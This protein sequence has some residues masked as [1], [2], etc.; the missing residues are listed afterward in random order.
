MDQQGTWTGLSDCNERPV[1]FLR[2]G[3]DDSFEIGTRSG[4]WTLTSFIVFSGAGR[5][6]H[7]RR[8]I[9]GNP[10]GP[11]GRKVRDRSCASEHGGPCRSPSQLA[12][13]GLGLGSAKQ[14]Q[15]EFH[16]I[17][18]LSPAYDYHDR[19]RIHGSAGSVR[20]LRQGL[21]RRCSEMH[22]P[23]SRPICAGLCGRFSHGMARATAAGDGAGAD[24]A[25]T[26]PSG[27]TAA[28]AAASRAASVGS[29][30]GILG[31]RKHGGSA[32]CDSGAA[33][34]MRPPSVARRLRPRRSRRPR[35]LRAGRLQ[36][37]RQALAPRRSL[38]RRLM[39]R[40]GLRY[41]L[42]AQPRKREWTRR[43][44][45][46]LLV[47]RRQRL[48]ALHGQ[49]RRTRL[50]DARK[51]GIAGRRAA[52]TQDEVVCRRRRTC[53][54]DT[55]L[56]PVHRHDPLA[57]RF[58]RLSADESQCPLI[59]DDADVLFAL[60]LEARPEAGLAL[61]PIAGTECN[62]RRGETI[63]ERAGMIERLVRPDARATAVAAA[64]LSILAILTIATLWSS[65]A[66]R[67]GAG[68]AS[69]AIHPG[70]HRAQRAAD[71]VC[72][73]ARDACRRTRI[74]TS[75]TT[76]ATRI[77]AGSNTRTGFARRASTGWA[78]RRRTPRASIRTST[79]YPGQNTIDSASRP[80]PRPA[81]VLPGTRPSV[82]PRR[83]VLL[84]RQLRPDLR[85]RP[86]RAGTGP[87]SVSVLLQLA[88]RRLR[89]DR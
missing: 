21:R 70:Y 75:S 9:P 65:A 88:A 41:R 79:A 78:G 73:D 47:L 39:R 60:D 61:A 74:A 87:L 68:S 82:P 5:L 53:P 18:R 35:R 34:A 71:A 48:L 25:A 89:A 69:A 29:S 2:A 27:T 28:R 72:V 40:S 20:S 8:S 3:V 54:A 83:V 67:P 85:P 59:R 58:L 37:R 86:D 49:R 31:H 13:L 38:G 44:T 6:G 36:R 56:C 45:R 50:D 1:L 14:A 17:P 55:R 7:D 15:A 51:A 64:A 80:W 76:P 43:W 62:D 57:A 84:V 32:D 63:M 16:T 81:Q 19:R 4:R 24:P 22:R 30:C 26:A 23:A 33:Q 52:Q 46:R 42:R 12:A 66:A 10:G 77:T 11:H